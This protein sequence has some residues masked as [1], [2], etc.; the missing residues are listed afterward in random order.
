M[1]PA[2][3]RASAA[4]DPALRRPVAPVLATPVDAVPDGPGL[5]HQPKWD[6]WRCL[7]FRHADAVYLQSRTGKDLTP[8]FPDIIRAVRPLPAGVVLDG[9]LVVWQHERTNFALLQRRVTAGTGLLRM[10][11]E[12]PAHYVVFDLLADAEGRSWMRRWRSGGPVSPMSSPAQ[13]RSSPSARTP[14]M[15]MRRPSG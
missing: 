15:P 2:R 4:A 6:G 11:R 8:Y 1:S 3:R 9:E 10:A 7:A 12:H 14:P 5:V 13:P